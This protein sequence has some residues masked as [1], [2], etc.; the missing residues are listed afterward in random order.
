MMTLVSMT[1]TTLCTLHTRSLQWAKRATKD[2]SEANEHDR[3]KCA[4][5]MVE[6][7]VSTS[8]VFFSLPLC[9]SVFVPSLCDIS[10]VDLSIDSFFLSFFFCSYLFCHFL[11]M[12]TVPVCTWLSLLRAMCAHCSDLMAREIDC[13]PSW[14]TKAA[15]TCH[16]HY[17]YMSNKRHRFISTEQWPC[18]FHIW[19][20]WFYIATNPIAT[21]SFAL[22]C[23]CTVCECE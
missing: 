11:T 3:S 4:I 15:V 6:M 5:E 9:L 23:H 8:R 19:F 21:Q 2:N 14:C 20:Y 10:V 17:L 12:H 1:R 22:A 7:P 13:Q 16:C 18:K